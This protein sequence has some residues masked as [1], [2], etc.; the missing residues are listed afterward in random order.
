MKQINEKIYI[1]EIQ[2]TSHFRLETRGCVNLLF[3]VEF[4]NENPIS[5]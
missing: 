5:K 3:N 4:E 2:N 1:Y